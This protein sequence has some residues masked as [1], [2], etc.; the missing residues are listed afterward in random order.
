[1]RDDLVFGF[2]DLHQVP[3]FVRL[4]CLSLTDHLGLRFKHTDDFALGSRVATQHSLT[5][6]PHDLLHAGNHLVQ[7][8]LGFLQYFAGTA[9]DLT[10]NLSGELLGL[11][12]HPAGDVQ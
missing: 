10:G 3:K 12:N 7:L 2:L 4:A 1:M 5:R 6:L 11:P 8:P 9:F